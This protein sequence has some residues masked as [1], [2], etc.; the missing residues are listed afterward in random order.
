MCASLQ[1]L[2]AGTYLNV[3]GEFHS[4]AQNAMPFNVI[5]RG[6]NP[7]RRQ[8]LGCSKMRVVMG[9]ELEI[10]TWVGTCASEWPNRMLS[11]ATDQSPRNSVS[12]PVWVRVPLRILPAR[13]R[14]YPADFYEQ[15]GFGSSPAPNITSSR[16]TKIC[17]RF[18]VRKLTL[19]ENEIEMSF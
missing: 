1:R 2:N 5:N 19:A 3:L 6:P 8:R 13:D 4:T 11:L 17:A 15:S 18:S 10:C 14:P 12:N 16:Q 7:P 9:W